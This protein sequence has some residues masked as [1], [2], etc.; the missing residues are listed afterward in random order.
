M[1]NIASNI[2]KLIDTN[3][4]VDTAQRLHDIGVSNQLARLATVW[5]PAHVG[6]ISVNVNSDSRKLGFCASR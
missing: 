5:N 3:Q 2:V 4:A 6:E 1:Q